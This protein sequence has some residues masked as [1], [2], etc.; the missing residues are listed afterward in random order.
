M[1]LLVGTIAWVAFFLVCMATRKPDPPRPSLPVSDSTVEWAR[2]LAIKGVRERRHY[3]RRHA[4][5]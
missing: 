5:R 3:Q 2:N 1:H 4:A